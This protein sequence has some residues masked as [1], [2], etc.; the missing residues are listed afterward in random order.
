M[1]R[2]PK[3]IAGSGHGI[4]AAVQG[5]PLTASGKATLWAVALLIVSS[6]VHAVDLWTPGLLDRSGRLKAS[7]YMRL[8]ATG[9]LADEGRWTELFDADA[10]VRI[11]RARIDPRLQMSGL[12]PNYGP[13]A[14]LLLAPLS[15]L[16][17]LGSWALFMA[18]TCGALLIGLWLLAGESPGLR[19][20]RGLAVLAAAASPALFET[21][22]YGQLS[23][24]TTLAFAA[25]AWLDSRGRPLAAGMVVGLAFYKP[26]LVLPALLIGLASRRWAFAAGLT[27]GITV[28]LAIGLGGGGLE[29]TW[30]W[31][32]VLGVLARSPH[33]V[34]G[35]P[36]EVHSFQGMFRLASVGPP[37]LPILTAVSAL[38]AM[39]L[40]AF[41]WAAGTRAPARWAA[42]VLAT[43]LASP[44]LL[45]Y[46]LLLLLIP[47][48]LTFE[49]AATARRWRTWTLLAA[50]LYL[51]PLYSPAVA[52]FTRLQLSTVS[53]AALLWWLWS[54]R[55]PAVQPASSSSPSINS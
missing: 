8:Y 24:V 20:H 39:A 22:R 9:A 37:L 45:T 29:T 16:P 1:S 53:M 25:G 47:L 36:A 17:L 26:N 11:A 49:P 55:G 5:A 35:F 40:A 52:E 10:H 48:M 38:A 18:A 44:H 7:D 2:A 50:L 43:L 14:A 30:E 34:Q 15:R 54:G 6:A 41:V 28:H 23:A 3:R 31:F 27:L 19:H 33:L 12:R 46:D 4:Q 21:L 42:L 13:T 51:A 32:K